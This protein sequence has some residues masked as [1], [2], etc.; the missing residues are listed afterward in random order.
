MTKILYIGDVHSTPEEL[1][2]CASLLDFV[3]RTAI[4]Q[5]PDYIVFLGD[6]FHRFDALSIRL[7][8]FWREWLLKAI[9]DFPIYLLVGNHDRIGPK[10]ETTRN[11]MNSF[12]S[13]WKSGTAEWTKVI[14]SPTHIEK[15]IFAV[16]Y[17][18]SASFVEAVGKANLAP[19]STVI[20]HQ[21]FNG[22]QYDNGFYIKDGI[23]METVQGLQVISGHIHKPSEFGNVWYP[24]APRWQT[25][26]DA[27]VDRA[28]WL[29][30]HA[31]DG[32]IVSRT[33]FDTHGVVPKIWRYED[34]ESCPL[35]LDTFL[36]GNKENDMP[37]VFVHGDSERVRLRCI[38]FRNKR[39]TTRSC[40]TNETVGNVKESMGIGKAFLEFFEAYRP[41]NKSDPY[42]LACMA[43]ERIGE[44]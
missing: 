24:G 2:E 1:D 20:C 32:S 34:K 27:N 28:I 6:Q 19:G 3:L 7:L 31:E 30:E 22:A 4:E 15:N 35:N 5:D 33:A 11:A 13:L 26:T 42:I 44:E 36:E 29:V 37:V 38:E 40:I 39:C 9:E 23:P 17:M 12:D 14:R 41:P 43:Q 21:E 8:D 16:P 25:L 10:D 18:S